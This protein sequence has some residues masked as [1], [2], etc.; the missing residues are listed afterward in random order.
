MLYSDSYRLFIAHNNQIDVMDVRDHSVIGT[1]LN[2]DPRKYVYQLSVVGSK[3]VVLSEGCGTGPD[4]FTVHRLSDLRRLYRRQLDDDSCTRSI[5]AIGDTVYI[6]SSSFR[7]I[8]QS[9]VTAYDLRDGT[10]RSALEIPL[11]RHVRAVP[12]GLLVDDFFGNL[13]MVELGLRRVIA[14]PTAIPTRDLIWWPALLASASAED[15]RVFVSNLNDST[16]AIVDYGS[17]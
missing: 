4:H 12:A 3:V 5:E 2:D 14:G 7:D 16:V 15:G 9:Q 17:R 6:G 13:T 11:L 1:I 10:R 8:N